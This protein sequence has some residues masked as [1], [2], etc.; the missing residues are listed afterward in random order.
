MVCKEWTCFA[1]HFLNRG[2]SSRLRIYCCRRLSVPS[3]QNF[4]FWHSSVCGLHCF[5]NF[6]L[7]TTSRPFSHTFSLRLHFKTLF[8]HPSFVIILICPNIT[9]YLLSVSSYPSL[10]ICMLLYLRLLF[11]QPWS[12]SVDDK[13]PIID[14]I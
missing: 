6:T 8:G 5:F 3:F 13:F 11:F 10:S 4:L 7:S 9:S 14:L 2:S 1:T 12:I